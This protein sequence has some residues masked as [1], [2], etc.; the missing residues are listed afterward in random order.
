MSLQNNI[1]KINS[2][3]YWK[4]M[5]NLFAEDEKKKLIES[6]KK[7]DTEKFYN[8]TAMMRITNTLKRVK[9]QEKK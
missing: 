4:Q 7:S 5:D 8:F 9:V 2:D 3:E 1:P 6:I